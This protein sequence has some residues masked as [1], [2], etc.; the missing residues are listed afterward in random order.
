MWTHFGDGGPGPPGTY[1]YE[2]AEHVNYF[3]NTFD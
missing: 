2:R 3:W 1:F